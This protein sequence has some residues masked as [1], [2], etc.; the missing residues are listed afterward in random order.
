MLTRVSEE[1]LL[2]TPQMELLRKALL[3]DALRFY[4]RF[5]RQTGSDPAVRRGAGEAYR[6]TGHIYLQIGRPDQAERA[7]REAIAVFEKLAADSPADPA[8]RLALALSHQER[9]DALSRLGQYAAAEAAL[10]RAIGLMRGL[11]ADFPEDDSYRR[12]LAAMESCLAEVSECLVQVA[13]KEKAEGAAR[14]DLQRQERLLAAAPNDPP[15]RYAVASR[16]WNWAA[17][18]SPTGRRR[19]SNSSATPWPGMGN[20]RA[21][22]LTRP[23]TERNWPEPTTTCSCSCGRAG[24]SRRPRR[25]FGQQRPSLE[26]LITDAPTLVY[27]RE[28][29]VE[30]YWDYGLMLEKAGRPREAEEAFRQ[31]VARAEAMWAEFPTYAWTPGRL[32]LVYNYVGNTHQAAGRLAEAEAAY[33]KALDV[34]ERAVRAL[35]QAELRCRLADSCYYLGMLLMRKGQH[36]GGDRRVSETFRAGPGQCGRSATPSPGDWRPTPT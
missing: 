27:P 7:Y 24:G 31:A 10:R 20:W 22:S 36:P 18:C 2:N 9:G 1:K 30:Y 14:E 23:S 29:L 5:L 6:R 3:E 13:T 12:P 8:D 35:P 16:G 19:P 4:Q 21:N 11:T 25:C 33:R 26:K 34:S 28:L 32:A 17:P 15:R